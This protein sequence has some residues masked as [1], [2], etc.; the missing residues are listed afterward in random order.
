MY[1]IL[2]ATPCC[3]SLASTSARTQL[4]RRKTLRAGLR[5][6]AKTARKMP[7]GNRAIRSLTPASRAALACA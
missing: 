6:L 2:Y 1:G 7:M 4:T 5:A 3:A